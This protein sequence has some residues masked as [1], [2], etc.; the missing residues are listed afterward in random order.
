M[1]REHAIRPAVCAGTFYP[2]VRLA[3][4]TAVRGYL[5]EVPTGSANEAAPKALIAPHAGYVY[6]GPVAACAY[7]RLGERRGRITRVVLIGPSHRVFLRGL[8]APDVDAFATPLGDVPVDR[9]WLARALALPQVQ[10]S[11]RAHAGEHSLEVQLPF[12]Q[13]TLG[14]FALVPLVAGDASAEEVAEVLDTLWGGDETLVVVSSDLSHYEPYESARR[15]DAATAHAIESRYPEAIGEDD[16]CG[17]V[18]IRGLLLVARARGLAVRALDLR[19]SGDTA[20]TRDR[21]VGYGS[22]AVG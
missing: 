3:L 8:A 7:A 21:V 11:N 1:P 17:C 16:A 10:V 20:G 5:S 2:G 12:L 18:P 13:V 22:F 9:A 19:S 6:S 14:A 15:L 4:D